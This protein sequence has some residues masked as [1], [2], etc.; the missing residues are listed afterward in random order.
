MGSFLHSVSVTVV[1]RSRLFLGHLDAYHRGP[2]PKSVHRVRPRRANA[3]PAVTAGSDDAGLRSDRPAPPHIPEP[4]RLLDRILDTPSL[5]HVVP[6]LRPELMHRLIQH[7][8]LEDC[9]DLVALATPGQLADI[10]D[11]DLWRA[12]QPGR[13]EQFDADR[14]G[15]WLEVLLEAGASVAAKTVAAMDVDLVIAGLAQH[16]LVFDPAARSSAPLDEEEAVGRALDDGAG[17]EVGGYL[18]VAT[19]TD[20]WDAIVTVLIALEAEYH[21]CFHCVMS[22]C[23]SLSN[24]R[25]EIDGLDDL[26]GDRA[27]VMFE[28]TSDR[29]QRRE[30][31]G[32]VTA[33]QAGAFLQMSRHLRLE[34]QAPPLDNP[35]ARGYFRDIEWPSGADAR[36]GSSHVST[37][38]SPPPA[39]NDSIDSIAAVVEILRDAGVVTPQPLALLDGP[40]EQTPRLHY[41]RAQL[42]FVRDRD[43]A[44]YSMRSRELAYLANTILAGCSIRARAFTVQEASDAA[45]A[46]CNLGLENWPR[47]WM[48]AE[49]RGGV[50]VIEPGTALPDDFL[51][52]HDLVSVF[53][54]GWTVLHHHVCM[55]S[56]ERL[57]RVLTRLRCHDLETQAGLDELRVG[58]ARQWRAGTPWRA[59][60]ALDVL[61]ILDLPASA[62]L[63][64]LIDECPVIHAS[65]GASRGS[66]VYAVSAADF[67]FIAENTQIASV[68][69]YMQSLPQILRP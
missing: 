32:Y 50:A 63:L 62:A 34:D 17:C 11:L 39:A 16:L 37:A 20:S 7:C 33:A 49:R 35:V 38:S 1:C 22:G 47:Q 13:D 29:E 27:Q 3:V 40:Q 23:R 52:G 42:Q 60:E 55:Y 44:A 67:E 10:F 45:V 2:M 65:L 31:K 59:R 24:S 36:S 68:R 53:Q 64:G 58:L 14:F 6:Q 19:R 48:T 25:P 43:E 18:A 46:V 61:A 69:E 54:V 15:V 4:R 21:D 66:R 8:G 5:A 12:G 26:L 30:K 9:S 41:I 51:A 28:L 57:V 56:A